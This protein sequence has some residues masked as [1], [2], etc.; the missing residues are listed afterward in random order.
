[1]I[2]AFCNLLLLNL[3]QEH[4][5]LVVKTFLKILFFDVS[6]LTSLDDLLDLL[7]D[8]FVTLLELIELRVKH[9]HVILETVVLFLGLD[10]GGD[11]FL[12]IRD[13][14]GLLD[15]VKRIFDYFYVSQILLHQFS[16]FSVCF[17][18]LTESSFKDDDGI[19]EIK[20]LGST[21]LSLLECFIKV[22]T[23]ALEADHV[24]LLLEL[25]LQ[26]LDLCL[27]PI[28]LLFMLCLEGDNLVI[29]FLGQF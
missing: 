24:I 22:G 27:E 28:F 20:S 13:T 4:V 14:S 15:L 9:V 10:E 29:G 3:L 19:R 21:I 25:E 7:F 26:F 23:V 5:A 6:Q 12:D 18:D 1:M 2:K 8:L 16:F 17:L 11:Y